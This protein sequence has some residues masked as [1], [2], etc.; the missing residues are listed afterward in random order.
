MVE[1][2]HKEHKLYLVHFRKS[3]NWIDFALQELEALVC[4]LTGISHV[5][6]RATQDLRQSR[7]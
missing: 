3:L 5:E 1:S 7:C 6:F 4:M 2:T